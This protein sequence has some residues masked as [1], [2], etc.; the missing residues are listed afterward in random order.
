[1]RDYILKRL[2]TVIPILIGISFLSFALIS[3]SPSNPAEVAL[4]VNEIVPTEEAVRAMEEQLGTNKL[5]K[6]L[7][8]TEDIETKNKEDIYVSPRL[9]FVLTSYYKGTSMDGLTKKLEEYI[10]NADKSES[11]INYI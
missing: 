3:L 1:M 11:D 7:G 5:K 9:N 8:F 4:R 6:Y 2:A 10:D